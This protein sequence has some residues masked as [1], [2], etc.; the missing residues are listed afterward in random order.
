MSLTLLIARSLERLALINLCETLKVLTIAFA[1]TIIAFHYVI[2]SC[3]TTLNADKHF[4]DR[5]SFLML[6]NSFSYLCCSNNA[7]TSPD[8]W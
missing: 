8:Y 3:Y 4:T 2:F 1:S 6:Y 7:R 5:Q